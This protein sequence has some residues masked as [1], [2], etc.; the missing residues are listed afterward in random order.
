MI[1]F[2][3]VF[4]YVSLKSH[5]DVCADIVMGEVICYL[6]FFFIK[7]GGIKNMVNHQLIIG[8]LDDDYMRVY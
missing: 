7:C 3:K 2:E 4:G 1:N 5:L 6:G 8:R